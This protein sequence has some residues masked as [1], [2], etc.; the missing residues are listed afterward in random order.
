MRIIDL[1][2]KD[3][4]LLGASAADKQDAIEK[5]VELQAKSG[6]LSDKE[7]YKQ[8]ILAREAMSSTAIE[9]GIAVPHAKSETVTAPSLCAMTLKE[10]VDYGAMDG[11]PSDLFFMIAAPL[12]GDL[13]LEILSHLMVLLMDPQFLAALRGAVL[14]LKNTELHRKQNHRRPVI[15]FLLLQLAQPVLHIPTWQ[16]KPWKKLARKWESAS[17]LRPT[18]A[19]A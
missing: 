1:I 7:V 16:Q 10:G 3:R 4:I 17:K 9:A 8:A 13:H 15:R 2:T 6:N 18:A 5:M 14:K 19:A 11:Q 12:N